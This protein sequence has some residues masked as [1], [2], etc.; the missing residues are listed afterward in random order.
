MLPDDR[1]GA[2]HER[3]VVRI[4]GISGLATHNLDRAPR[5]PVSEGDSVD[6]RGE[7]EW[8]PK[9]GVIHWTRR[10]PDDHHRAGWIR[11]QGRLYQ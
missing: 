8:N 3:F 9:G 11:H 5:V 6:L 1:E 10:D 7:Y 4:Q 2:R